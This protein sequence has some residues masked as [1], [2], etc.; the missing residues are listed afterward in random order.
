MSKETSPNI[1]EGEGLSGMQR[2]DMQCT[3]CSKTFIAE[4]DYSLNGNHIIRCA[5]C[6]H[7]HCRT[8]QGGKVTDQRWAPSN[9]LPDIPVGSRHVWKSDVENIAT[10]SA[11][12]FLRDRW[13]NRGRD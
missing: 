2:T 6:G 12:A 3:N 9:S 4:M 7:Q 10:A 8:V 11:S 13:L 1:L 5:W